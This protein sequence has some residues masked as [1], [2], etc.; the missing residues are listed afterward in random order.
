MNM[1][2][3]NNITKKYKDKLILDN[4]TLNI[5]NSKINI[6]IGENG[7][8]KSTLLK[9]IN[10]FINYRGSIKVI[11]NIT[12]VP[13]KI[14]LPSNIKVIDFLNLI[15]SVKKS[16]YDNL[17]KLISKFNLEDHLYKLVSE[18]SYGTKQKLILIQA[19][20]E[21]SDIYLFDEPLNG[22]DNNS[23][24]AFLNEIYSLYELNKLILI[25]THEESRMNINNTRYIKL[26]NG[27]IC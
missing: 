2:Q 11:G 5:D 16:T 23:I 10:N 18:L 27:K 13:E 25:V 20:I 26:Q 15:I 3:L 21:N 19:L 17:G 7:C 8:G 24:K 4:I 6:I 9:C 1:I 22:L 12:Y 14:I